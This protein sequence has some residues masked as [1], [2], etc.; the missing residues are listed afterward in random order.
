MFCDLVAF[1]LECC[2]RPE[3]PIIQSCLS[4]I[5]I[6][7]LG[8]TTYLPLHQGHNL[9]KDRQNSAAKNQASDWLTWPSWSTNLKNVLILKYF[10]IFSNSMSHSEPFV[11]LLMN[12]NRSCD[13]Y[14][15]NICKAIGSGLVM[16]WTDIFLDKHLYIMYN[17]VHNTEAVNIYLVGLIAEG[18][19]IGTSTTT[20]INSS[21][22]YATTT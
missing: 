12:L 20:T 16:E 17:W 3:C 9:L 21:Q 4:Y 2:H 18:E 15:H 5:V 8:T 10:N 19:S 13:I 22:H 7:A 14:I 1:S 6:V 11:P